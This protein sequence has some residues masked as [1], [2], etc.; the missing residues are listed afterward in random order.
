MYVP[1]A[2][3]YREGQRCNKGGLGTVVDDT[4]ENGR[5]R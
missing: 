1:T 2:E 4:I 5:V 3:V